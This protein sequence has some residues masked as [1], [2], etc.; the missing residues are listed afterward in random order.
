MS[1]P[2]V[3]DP[4]AAP[5][6]PALVAGLV[7]VAAALTLCWPMLTGQFLLGSDQYVAGYGFRLFGAEHF[8]AHGEIPL[9]NPYLFGGMPFVAAMHGDI[10]YP[11]AWLRWVLP[12]DTA[13]NLGFAAHLVLA[14]ATMYAL[15]RALGAGWAAALTGGLAWELSGIVAS[16]VN[17]GHDGKLFVSAVTPL[18]FLAILRLVRDRRPSAVGLLGLTVGLSLHGHP[19]MSYYLLVAGLVWGVALVFASPVRPPRD[20]L[21]PVIAGALGGVAL[22]FGLY[23]IQALPF[24]EYIPFSPRGEGGDSGGWAYATAFSMPVDEL[25]SLVLP[26]FNGVLDRYWGGNFFKL[27]T[28]Y[29]GVLPLLLAVFGAADRERRWVVLALG[30][31]AG[32]FL[33]VSFGGH[34]PFYRLWYEVMPMMKKVRAPG[35]AFF[36]V[37]FV[38]AVYAGF[39]VDRLLRGEVPAR[40]VLGLAGAVAGVAGLAAVGVLQAVAESLASA[41]ML[42]RAAANATDL[43]VGGIRLLVAAVASGAVLWLVARRRLHGL[44]AGAMLGAVVVADLYSVDR[45]FFPWSAPA[46]VTYRDD[47]IT[48]RVRETPLPYR[49]LDVGVYR[50]S[51]LMAHEVPTLL[52][53]HGNEIRFFDDLLGGKNEWRNLANPAIWD[54]YAIRYLIVGQPVELPGWTLVMGPVPTTTGGQGY[55]Y[56]APA[57]PAWARVVPAAAKVPDPRVVPTVLDERFPLDQ[58]VLLPDTATADP[59]PLGDAVAPDPGIGVVVRHWQPGAMTLGLA[60]PAPA[61]SWLLVSENWYPAWTARVD[62]REV[63]A[64]RGQGALLTVP[65]AEG[66]REVELAFRSRTYERGRLVST[67]SAALTLGLLG[68]PILR[69]TRPHA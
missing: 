32:L 12:V 46:S 20:R 25:M 54:L 26:E 22:G 53:Y 61:G 37:A 56:E 27:H 28:E 58:V 5:R 31:V 40:R 42:D 47:A 6:R 34:T 57:A 21:V 50:G 3:P 24:I 29:L 36:L 7:F 60:S 64:Y 30:A 15:L 4:L 63:A 33:L 8:R 62:G 2:P 55:L 35:M 1:S 52:G 10:F 39:G 66:A 45:Q 23:A 19:Q 44:R 51:W 48:S 67:L 49:T 43:Q 13:M 65:L 16:L 68:L 38:G 11:T 41:P 17:P 69:R 14:G 9:W 59:A 18:L